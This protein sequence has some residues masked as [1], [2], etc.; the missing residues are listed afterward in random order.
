[1]EIFQF[2]NR[3]LFYA[4]LWKNGKPTLSPRTLDKY[5]QNLEKWQ[6][7]EYRRLD[8]GLLPTKAI[9]VAVLGREFSGPNKE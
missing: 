7:E 8:R 4:D 5:C 3:M 2:Q 1:M 6:N 9:V